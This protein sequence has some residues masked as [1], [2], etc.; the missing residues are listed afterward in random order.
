MPGTEQPAA[1]GG[2]T[3]GPELPRGA[4]RGTGCWEGREHRRGHEA[5]K[6][7]RCRPRDG[8]GCGVWG[9]T[10]SGCHR[11]QR[12]DQWGLKRAGGQGFGGH[13]KEAR[14]QAS[15]PPPPAAPRSRTADVQ[16]A[17][18]PGFVQVAFGSRPVCG[19]ARGT[20]GPTEPPA[21]SPLGAGDVT[22]VSTPAVD[23]F[24]PGFMERDPPGASTPRPTHWPAVLG[25]GDRGHAVAPCPTHPSSPQHLHQ[26]VWGPRAWSPAPAL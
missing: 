17:C 14:K 4:G 19:G 22:P 23:S 18:G 3:R 21:H 8:P 7:R 12:R 9:A 15:E 6:G 24:P 25:S 10:I 11:R 2:P 16:R 20:Q 13:M 5:G 1:P 26:R